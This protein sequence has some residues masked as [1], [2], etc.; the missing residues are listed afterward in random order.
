VKETKGVKLNLGAGQSYIPGF[1]N[2]DLSSRAEVSLDLGKDK[3]PFEDDSVDVIF[4]Y[5]TLEHVPDYLFALSQIH[6]VL[7]HGG[8]LLLGLP[9]V[10][11]TKYHLVNPYHLHNF[12]EYSFDFFDQ[13]LLKGSA[14]E[15][16]GISFK[17]V[18]HRF[19]Y[20]SPFNLVPPPLRTWCRRHL[21]NVVRSIDYGLVAVKRPTG[22][23]STASEGELIRLFDHCLNSR[24]SY[25]QNSPLAASA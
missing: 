22:P 24:T 10:T 23:A 13:D 4:S 21:L 25:D 8:R 5:H 2:I 3:L 17:K 16:N 20:V 9:Y 15:A 6:R 18:F 19:H 12:N 1:V 11:L 14:V 7:K